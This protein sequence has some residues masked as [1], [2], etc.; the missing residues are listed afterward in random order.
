VAVPPCSCSAPIPSAF[1]PNCKASVKRLFVKRISVVKLDL[2]RCTVLRNPKLEHP[3]RRIAAATLAASFAAALMV[4]GA[5]LSAARAADST[6]GISGA[7]SDGTTVDDR[8]RFSYQVDPGQHLDDFYLVRNTGT[9]PQSMKVFATDAFNTAKGDF[10]LLDTKT[11]PKDAGS[12]VSFSNGQPSTVLPLASGESKIVSFRLTVPANASPGDH[13]GGIVIS[14]ATSQGNIVV[15]RRVATRMYVRVK[16]ALQPA[17]TV[18]SIAA[19]YR[20]TLNPLFGTT[21]LKFTVRNNGNV[22]LAANMVAQVKTFFGIGASRLVNASVAEMLPGSTRVVTV[23]I[24]GVPQIGYLNPHLSLAPTI[25][26]DALSPGPLRTTVRDVNIFVMPWWLLILIAVAAVLWGF[27]VLRRKRDAVRAQQWIAHMETEAR[28]TAEDE[29][30]PETI[31]AASGSSAAT[32]PSSAMT[33]GPG[34]IDG[35]GGI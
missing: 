30:T 33:Q 16:G 3:L 13:A 24:P 26:T 7:P 15:D 29:R 22:A 10:G 6:N 11:Q 32:T 21:D 27:I 34:R 18:G 1:D 19:N 25:D 9:T 31:G 23:E 5:A 8:S 20:P 35:S 12:W 2:D 14:A 4:A 17:L 28:R